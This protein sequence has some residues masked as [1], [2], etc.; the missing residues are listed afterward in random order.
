MNRRVKEQIITGSLAGLLMERP[1][2]SLNSSDADFLV[3]LPEVRSASPT[4]NW[5]HES[6]TELLARQVKRTRDSLACVDDEPALSYRELDRRSDNLA[7][8]QQKQGMKLGVGREVLIF[9]SSGIHAGQTNQSIR[10]VSR[11]SG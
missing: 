8:E 5:M 11:T 7:R 3:G 1:W 9:R 2:N 4:E 6:I 10:A